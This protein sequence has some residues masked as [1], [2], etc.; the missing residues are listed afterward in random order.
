MILSDSRED[1]SA[2]LKIFDSQDCCFYY[3]ESNN[4]RKLWLKDNNFNAPIDSDFILGGVMHFG[5]TCMADVDSLK[6]ALQLQKSTKEIKFKHISKGK[7]FID[8][9]SESKVE[10]FL[11]WLYQSDL[12]VHFSNINNLYWA[13]IDIVDTIEESGYIPFNI[14]MKNELYKIFR[15]NYDDFYQLLVKFNF[16]NIA[17]ENIRFFYQGILDFIDAIPG[18]LSFE[19]EILRQG[20]KSACKQD[21]LVFLQGN[22]EKTIINSYFPFYLRP[23]GLFA[24]AQHIFDNEYQIKE[25]FIKCGFLNSNTKTYTY[26]FVNSINNPFIQISDC[27]V[28]LLGKYYTYINGINIDDADKMINSIPPKQKSVLKMF[29][30]VL[31][32][33]EDLSKLLFC[34]TESMEEHNIASFIFNNVL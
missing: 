5:K 24:S 15:S 3:D 25:Q 20:M 26:S 23:I 31:K 29:I 34:G 19:M 30:Q 1:I 12:Y 27:I 2:E 21:D 11:Q 32:K 28:G 9:L 8:C 16:P 7:T 6:K 13:I 14:E 18:E 22:T 33:S 10:L 17:A 4:I